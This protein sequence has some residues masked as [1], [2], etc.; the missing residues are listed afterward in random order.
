MGHL[1]GCVLD[2]CNSLF[3][4]WKSLKNLK[5]GVFDTDFKQVPFV[6]QQATCKFSETLHI[7][8]ACKREKM[9]FF[10]L[11][12]PFWPFWPTTGQNGPFCWM[13]G[14][15]PLSW[16]SLKNLKVGVFETYFKQIPLVFRQTTC[17]YSESWGPLENLSDP[18]PPP[19]FFFTK[20][21][22]N[23]FW[24]KKFSNGPQL[25]EYVWVVCQNM[26]GTCLKSVP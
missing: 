24:V 13:R 10:W 19:R 12:S 22:Q 11:F 17:T 6:F 21:S 9:R 15:V 26:K 1:A 14:R 25:S 23:R 8:R 2:V 3:K 7:L 5:V 18:Q 16:K 4:G 20:I